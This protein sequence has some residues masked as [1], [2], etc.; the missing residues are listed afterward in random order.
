MGNVNLPTPVLVAVGALCIL[1]GYLLGIVAG[2]D[3]PERTIGVVDSY[4][5]DAGVLCLSGEAVAELDDS[6][7]DGVDDGDD[8][9]VLCGLWQR[10]AGSSRPSSGE[11]FRFV[12]E[13]IDEA[14]E[15]QSSDGAGR[16]LIYGAV[17][18]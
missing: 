13:R 5:A 18:D 16:V 3:T 8:D 14:P 10:S 7:D 15:G 2:P 6:S 4:D 9:D 12:T 1:A 17:V 11:E